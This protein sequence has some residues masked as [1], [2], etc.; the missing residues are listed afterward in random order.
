MLVPSYSQLIVALFVLGAGALPVPAEGG[1]VVSTQPPHA[2]GTGPRLQGLGL[3]RVVAR[4]PGRD[5][6]VV[7]V[8]LASGHC[9]CLGRG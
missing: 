6:A 2:R 8:G 4:G 1:T 3:A 5:G 9:H 7:V